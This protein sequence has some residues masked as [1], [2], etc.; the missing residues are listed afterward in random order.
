MVTDWKSLMQVFIGIIGQF[1]VVLYMVAF[2]AFFWGIVLFIFNANDEKKRQDGKAWMGWSVVALFVMITIWG[3]V[4][5]FTDTLG[6]GPL[7]IPQLGTNP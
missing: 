3:I 2:A 1:M 6:L 4:G 7:I 5:L